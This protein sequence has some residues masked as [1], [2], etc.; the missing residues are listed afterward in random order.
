MREGHGD[1]LA[2]H[3]RTFQ[4]FEETPAGKMLEVAAML[5]P[6]APGMKVSSC[7]V[8]DR[9]ERPTPAEWAAVEQ[10]FAAV[11]SQLPV[12]K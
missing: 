1:S 11:R 6:L 7:A 12:Q 2:L 5:A 4:S 3:D 8:E 10:A 9:N